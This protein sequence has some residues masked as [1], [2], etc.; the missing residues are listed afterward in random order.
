MAAKG[1][2]NP[3]VFSYQHNLGQMPMNRSTGAAG[4]FLNKRL[5]TVHRSSWL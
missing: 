2:E 3:C 5:P 4:V 1:A